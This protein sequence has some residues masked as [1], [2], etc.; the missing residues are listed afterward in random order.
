MTF[1]STGLAAGDYFG[2]LVITSNDPDEPEIVAPV[3]MTVVGELASANFEVTPQQ[4]VIGETVYFS[5]TVTGGHGP[6]TRNWSFGDGGTATGQYVTHTYATADNYSVSLTVEDGSG[7]AIARHTVSV[8]RQYNYY[9]PII[10]L[11]STPSDQGPPLG[12]RDRSR[13]SE[14]IRWPFFAEPPAR[15]PPGP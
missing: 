3:Q 13:A 1:D 5:G 11:D 8:R 12:R 2:D 10:F 4:P 14:A 6:L 9:Q 7:Q 15:N